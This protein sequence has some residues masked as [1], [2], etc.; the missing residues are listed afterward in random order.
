MMMSE[1]MKTRFSHRGITLCLLSTFLVASLLIGNIVFAFAQTTGFP[2]EGLSQAVS[3]TSDSGNDDLHASVVYKG[4]LYLVWESTRDQ[5]KELYMKTFDGYSW[6][7]DI[8][9]TEN[10]GEDGGPALVI[11]NNLLYL[12]WH[13]TRDDSRRDVYYMTYDGEQ[14]S[15]ATA[16]FENIGVVDDFTDVT[17]YNGI[18]YLAWTSGRTGFYDLYYKMFDGSSWS[19]DIQLTDDPDPDLHPALESFDGKL[20]VQWHSYGYGADSWEILWK[21]FDGTE[22]SN[23]TSITSNQ[24]IDEG[25]GD[26]EVYQQNLY[27]SFSSDRDGDKEIY[28]TVYSNGA[29]S[30]VRKITDNPA[31]EWHSS[32]TVFNDKLYV[33]FQSDRKSNNDIYYK[34]FGEMPTQ[35]TLPTADF[36]WTP[37]TP[38]A[39]ETVIFDASSSLEGWNGA[40]WEPIVSYQWDFGNQT[41]STG[42]TV[43]HTF[44]ESGRHI[45]RLNITDSRGMQDVREKEITVIADPHTTMHVSLESSTSYVGFR[46]AING[47]LTSNEE[48]VSGAPVVLSYSVTGGNSWNDI[49]LVYTTAKGNFSAIWLPSATGNYLVK[50]SWAGNS[51]FLESSTVVSLSVIGVEEEKVF[52]VTSNSTVTQFSFNSTDRALAFSVTGPSGT[53]GY[54]KISMA[55]TLM[56]NEEQIKVY[57]DG[58]QVNFTSQETEDAYQIIFAYHHSTHKVVVTLG[59]VPSGSPQ[60]ITPL[61][62]ILLT[63]ALATITAL[64]VW[65]LRKEKQ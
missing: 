61:N 50:A 53:A 20:F 47:N 62:L 16:A 41:N 32:L 38:S 6:S 3:L 15:E 9:I 13:S 21:T 44:D 22:W 24:A 34:I 10:E 52:S 55:K 30:N 48:A 11:Y 31:Q 19:T 27:L 23:I 46:V 14:W 28:Y 36:T 25:P 8:Q 26:L 40:N 42:K 54:T 12:F 4:T 7:P 35:P 45:V 57:L 39:N 33:F 63:T 58:N 60:L 17:V 51:T 64:T 56:E 65:K 5:N 59:S 29:W 2:E 1:V 37:Y 49:T 18:L 43:T